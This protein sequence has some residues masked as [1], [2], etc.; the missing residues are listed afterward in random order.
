MTAK[1]K[2]NQLFFRYFEDWIELYKVVGAVRDV[3]L[4]KYY[5]TLQNL[6]LLAPN[7]RIYDLNR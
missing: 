2:A 5:M 1:K 7:L 6:E 4:K 3:T